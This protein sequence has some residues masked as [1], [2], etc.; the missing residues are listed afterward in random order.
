MPTRRILILVAG[1]FFLEIG[2]AQSTIVFSGIPEVKVS[3]GGVERRVDRLERT[4][5][6]NPS[7]VI[8]QIG[9]RYYWAS[10]ENASLIRIDSG[11]FTTFIAANGSGYVRIV[12]N[13]MKR[14]S[15]SARWG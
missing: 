6:V 15:V 11:A 5:A 4:Q 10:R 3:E 12:R 14:S 2:A 1:L 8:S 7:C 9:D 13:G